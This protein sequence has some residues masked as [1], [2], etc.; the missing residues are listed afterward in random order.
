[1]SAALLPSSFPRATRDT[2]EKYIPT[3][4]READL[5]LMVEISTDTMLPAATSRT[6]AAGF[7][8]LNWA[9]ASGG[10]LSPRVP[11]APETTVEPSVD[12]QRMKDSGVSFVNS[13]SE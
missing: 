6:A 1:M 5:D 4:Y 13:K 9:D 8:Y 11:V 2:L 7:Y 3:A 12:L 10:E